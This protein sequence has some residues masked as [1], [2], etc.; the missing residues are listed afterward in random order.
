MRPT[1]SYD[2]CDLRDAT[3]R[4]LH[5]WM[6]WRHPGHVRCGA[7]RRGGVFERYCDVKVNWLVINSLLVGPVLDSFAKRSFDRVSFN[8][9]KCKES[10][11]WPQWYEK[12]PKNISQNICHRIYEQ[13]GKV[14][15]PSERVWKHCP[16]IIQIVTH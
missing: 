9:R 10:G 13:K 4:M 14:R 6:V 2:L 15:P 1:D 3:A 12:G 11:T 5:V 16:L 8:R 7:A